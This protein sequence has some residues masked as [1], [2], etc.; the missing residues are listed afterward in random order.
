MFT[1]AVLRS[2]ALRSLSPWR[3]DLGEDDEDFEGD[4]EDFED[5]DA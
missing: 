3:Q 5:E 1:V 4:D 2:Q